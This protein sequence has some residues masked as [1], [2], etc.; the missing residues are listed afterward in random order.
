VSIIM[1]IGLGGAAAARRLEFLSNSRRRRNAGAA[2]NERARTAW[3]RILR[4]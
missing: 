4:K 2:G 1:L 3:F